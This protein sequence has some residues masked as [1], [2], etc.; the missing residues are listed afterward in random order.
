MSC[1]KTVR[2]AVAF[3]TTL[4]LLFLAGC[5]G[6]GD[7]GAQGPAGPGTVSTATT[8]DVEVTGVTIASPP[9]VDFYIEDQNGIP[10]TGLNADDIRFTIAQLDPGTN[11]EPSAWQSYINHTEA[12]GGVG[13]GTEDKV[14]A[15]YEQASDGTFVN[16]G[17]GSYTYT[18]AT[19]I[20]DVTSPV[21]ID[22][23]P[24]LTHRLAMQMEDG[25][26]VTNAVYTWQPSTGA[27]TD[28]TS[29]EIV[30]TDSCNE[31]HNQLAMHGGGRIDTRYCVTCHNPGSADAHSGNT[32]DFKVLIHKLH[33]GKSLPSVVAGGS[34]RIFGYHNSEHDFSD[35][36]F[37]QDVRNC[38]KC[39]D[40]SDS[41]TPDGD[42]WKHRP[43]AEACGACHDDVDFATG[44]GHQG[45]I[46][47]NSMCSDC[48][49]SGGSAGPVADAHRVIL[50]EEAEKYRFNLLGVTNTA[51][52]QLPVITYSVTDPR[53]GSTYDVATT[54]ALNNGRLTIDLAWSTRAGRSDYNNEG[55]PDA[56]ARAASFSTDP[57]ADANGDGTYTVTSSVAVPAGARGTGAAGLEG[58][59]VYDLNGDGSYGHDERVP[60]KSAVR[61]FP[62]TDATA[63][64]RREVV[65]TAKCQA[66][67][68][69]LSLHG[70]N[71]NDNVEVC[72][73]CHNPNN[74]DIGVRVTAGEEESIDFKRLIHGI[75]AADE[76]NHGFRE[77]GLVVYGY[78]SSVHDF[79]HVRFP[80]HLND[81]E[82]CHTDGT[83]MLP[84]DSDVAPS[85]VDTTA[86]GVNSDPASPDSDPDNDLVITPAAAVCSSCHDKDISQTHMEQ[87]GALFEVSRAQASAA[88]EVCEV[89]H[90]S[91]K[92]GDVA[93][94]HDIE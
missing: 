89:C 4:S 24:T 74:T 13:P 14:Q 3:V 6:S 48:H 63:Q 15:T 93:V 75:H 77:D 35:V 25:V 22:Y 9:V 5:G 57:A 43:S 86:A 83:Y 61:Y 68:E 31:C 60:V 2:H 92:T 34:Y 19:D 51:P 16:N 18:F 58:Y 26:P 27:T 42:N 62:V 67:H 79:S 33:M 53:D 71:R 41:A 65:A 81:C 38:T 28:I 90:A 55:T 44:S 29:R 10:F 80:G 70:G 11:G 32:V 66:C 49:A 36:V 50:A 17:D 47:D 69:N 54:P 21:A 59:A 30:A 52:G 40:G 8:L 39:H 37:P 82:T 87:H 1:R 12:A 72:V 7:D 73:L 56:P 64:E 84:L 91:G 20:T 85:V 88:V 23:D 94:V 76:D 78:R 46:V 45:G